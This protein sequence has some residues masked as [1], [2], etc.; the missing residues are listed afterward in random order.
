MNPKQS[1]EIAVHA[2]LTAEGR[3]IDGIPAEQI[4]KGI[5]N[6]TVADDEGPGVSTRVNP[7]VT[8]IADGNHEEIVIGTKNFRGPLIIQVEADGQNMTDADFNTLCEDVF[9]KLDIDNL[10][11]YLS[12]SASNFYCYQA[13]IIEHGDSVHNGVNW[14]NRI[15]IDTVYAQADL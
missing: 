11:S 10:R 14:Q 6:P 12:A 1:L 13:N 5:D 4:Y 2:F 9:S 7:S 15:V 3:E 8:I